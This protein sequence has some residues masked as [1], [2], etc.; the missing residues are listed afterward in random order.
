[1]AQTIAEKLAEKYD[2]TPSTTI[3]GTLKK[4]TNDETGDVNIA[5]LISKMEAGGSSSIRM[6]L[7]DNTLSITQSS[8]SWIYQSWS[9][10]HSLKSQLNYRYADT[11]KWI[12]N[13]D[14]EEIEGT[15]INSSGAGN[16][17]T[18]YY[19]GADNPG[20]TPGTYKIGC[21]FA[22]GEYIV[23]ISMVT[24]DASVFSTGEHSVKVYVELSAE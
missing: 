4:I 8:N 16:S 7:F 11:A 19:I 24:L 12:V 15:L 22:A 13:V 20:D 9:S 10:P 21:H 6:T 14:G 3:A 1:M 17:T 5:S 2:V 23:G 18:D